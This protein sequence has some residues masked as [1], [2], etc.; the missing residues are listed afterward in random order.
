MNRIITS[1]NNSSI[2]YQLQPYNGNNVLLLNTANSVGTLTLTTPQSYQLLSILAT[3]A[4]GISSFSVRLNFNDLTYTD[5]SF[6][7]PDWFDGTPYAIRNIGRVNARNYSNTVGE[8]YDDIDGAGTANNPRLYD[9]P[10]TLTSND[11]FKVLTS[12]TFTKTVSGSRTAVLAV[13]GLNPL[14]APVATAG[15]NVVITGFRTN[16]NSVSNA[17]K[18]RLDVSTTSDF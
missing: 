4:E 2:I 16:W 18:Y 12:I 1:A 10:I 9:C 7:V 14:L 15:T 8:R 3:S 5:Y 11:M 6:T 17:T 13:C